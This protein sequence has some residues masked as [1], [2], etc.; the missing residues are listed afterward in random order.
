MIIVDI[1]TLPHIKML[2][3]T[4]KGIGPKYPDGI[5]SMR[6]GEAEGL[7]GKKKKVYQHEKKKKKGVDKAAR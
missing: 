3:S 6:W 4:A 1:M 2:K 7:A 5:A